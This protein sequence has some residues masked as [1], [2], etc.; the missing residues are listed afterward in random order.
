M[1]GILID[2]W[3]KGCPAPFR[4]C[5]GRHDWVGV[6]HGSQFQPESLI[7]TGLCRRFHFVHEPAKTADESKSWLFPMDEL[8]V[9]IW[10]L[11][12][13]K[14]VE[15]PGKSHCELRSCFSLLESELKVGI[16]STWRS[17]WPGSVFDHRVKFIAR[18]YS[19]SA[20]CHLT[21]LSVESFHVS[22]DNPF[23][24]SDSTGSSGRKISVDLSSIHLIVQISISKFRKPLKS[25]RTLHSCYVRILSIQLYTVLYY[26]VLLYF[27]A[28]CYC[29]W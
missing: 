28:I 14:R 19:V 29:D 7:N 4:P 11:C 20:R 21:P 12:A 1:G 17:V 9:S 3:I 15:I 18:L 25:L 10:I 24:A 13:L 5:A 2:S 26:H 27:T 6:N 22:A 8:L 16:A 23:L